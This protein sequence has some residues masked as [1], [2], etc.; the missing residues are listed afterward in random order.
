MLE[1]ITGDI[2]HVTGKNKG[3]FPFSNS[4]II[5]TPDE[6]A[7]LIDTGCG[8]E[9]LKDLK[10][11]FKIS[12]VINSHTHPDHS[13]GNWL[14]DNDSISIS[15]PREGFE[16]AGNLRRLSER[17][18]E[19]GPLASTWREWV[20]KTMDFR[21]MKVDNWFDAHSTIE[22]GNIILEPIHTPGHT[23]DH[24]CFYESKKK[25]LFAF[26]YD[27]TSFGPWYGHRESDIGQFK[28]SIRRIMKLDIDIFVSGH[29]GVITNDI[30][31]RLKKYLSKFD[32]NE[33][34]VLNLLREG[35]KTLDEMT[36]LAPIYGAFPYAQAL[37]MYWEGNMIKMHLDDLVASGSVIKSDNDLFYKLSS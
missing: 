4:I 37:L 35:D 31:A 16:T 28:D 3:Y 15:V 9:T 33:S 7:V 19:P 36:Q 21:D 22:I 6:D 13:A 20:S 10:N 17:F 2:V 29:K 32:E 24:Y 11:K 27:L 26:D 14:F 34:K 23:A 25:I 5:L 8:I 12:R 30:K 18:T 1:N